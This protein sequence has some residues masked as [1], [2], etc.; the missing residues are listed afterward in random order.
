[1][2]FSILILLFTDPFVLYFISPYILNMH[3]SRNLK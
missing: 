2:F 1:M 3:K